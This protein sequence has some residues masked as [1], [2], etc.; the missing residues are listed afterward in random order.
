MPDPL[1]PLR[2]GRELA[3][4]L[5]QPKSARWAIEV[6]T[7]LGLRSFTVELPDREAAKT[8]DCIGSVYERLAE[9]NLGRHDVVVGV[10]GGAL[11]D[12]AGFV[13]ATW[14]RGVE[15]VL[16]PT[17][18]LGAVDAAIGGKTAINV[19]GPAEGA[20]KN[21]V[22]AFWL[23]S[24][25]VVD[26]DVLEAN[27]AAL[28]LE[29]TAEILKAGL[30]ADQEIV[31]LYTTR[32]LEAPLDELVPRAI[33]VKTGV[34]SEDLREAGQ[35]ALLNL[36][37]TVGHGLEAVTGMPH[38]F[39]VSIGMVAEGAIASTRYGFDNDWLTSLIFSLGLPVAASG[40]SASAVV[41]WMKRDKKRSAEGIKMAL[42]RTPGDLVVEV[43][44]D[45]E[46][47][48]GLQAVGLA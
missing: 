4:I 7:R 10:G 21:L 48:L 32:G 26:L 38:G 41:N 14:V 11:T 9:E 47:R 36:G 27:P 40:V 33:A 18:V 20:G 34:V 25:V 30:I 5:H 6:Q 19:A 46:L 22:G 45:E 1:L 2:E 12:V 15:V 35:R 28:L 23:P 3:A 31:D 13:A 43:V 29:G 16:V 8:L 39:A 37:H 24:R 42:I 44:S 17:T